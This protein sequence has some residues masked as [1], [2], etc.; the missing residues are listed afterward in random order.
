MLMHLRPALSLLLFF[1][2]LTGAIYPL[3]V[4]S[5]SE[6]FFPQQARGSLMEHE[7]RVVG[8]ALIGQRFTAPH[9]FHGRPSAAGQGYDA[10]ASSGSNLGP[11]SRALAERMAAA[12]SQLTTAHGAPPPRELLMASASGLDPHLT[13]EAAHYQVTRVAQARGMDAA[14]VRSLIEQHTE[15]RWLGLLG[16]PQINVLRLNLALNALRKP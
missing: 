14:V 6:A 9:Y 8:S 16:E 11:S 3:V 15:E 7:G 5:L 12:Q 13:P 4:W 1:S 2:L 10:A